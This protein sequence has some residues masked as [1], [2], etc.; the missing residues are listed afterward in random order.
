MKT[1][2]ECSICGKPLV[3]YAYIKGNKQYCSMEC[4]NKGEKKK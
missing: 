3:N 1:K 4:K 2:L